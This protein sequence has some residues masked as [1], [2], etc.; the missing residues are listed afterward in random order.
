MIA[1]DGTKYWGRYGAAGLLAVDE[2]RGVLLQKRVGW[3]HFGGTWGIPGGALHQNEAPA[4][5]AMRE[6]Q[7]EAGVPD[8]SVRPL[9][10]SVFDLGI[11]SYTTLVAVVEKSFEPVIADPESVALEWV[12]T[13]EVAQH[14]LHPGFASSWPM[15]QS[16]MN[17]RPVVVVDVANVMGATPNGW[18]K[19][20][21]GAANRVLDS[22]AELARSGVAASAL[23]VGGTRWFAPVIAV[24][25]GEARA[26]SDPAGITVARAS[27]SGDDEIVAIVEAE[28]ARPGAIV[29]VVTS[30]RGLR[31]R[32]VALGAVTHGVRWLNEAAR[33]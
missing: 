25:E 9:L 7:E 33:D 11:W 22:L 1:A 8:G 10:T 15:L 20:R 5:G 18:W 23:Q 27:G 19:D 6:S 31:E 17:V 30:D 4:Q 12:P 32:V 29:H 21:A 2:A 16:V 3:S 13:A 28:A 26:A 24:L 14:E